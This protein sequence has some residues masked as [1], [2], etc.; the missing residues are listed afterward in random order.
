MTDTQMKTYKVSGMTC[1]HCVAA[2]DGKVRTVQG[3]TDV[4]VDLASGD[5]EVR[6][7]AVDSTAIRAAVEEAGYS[8][9]EDV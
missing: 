9:R 7:N 8:L 5:V 2:V 1:E 6:G 4:S 3:V